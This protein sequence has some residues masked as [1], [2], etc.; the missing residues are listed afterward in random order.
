MKEEDK[1]NKK[2]GKENPFT[3]PEGYFDNL[4][5]EIMSKLP[6]KE[7][8]FT[9]EKEISMWQRVR[10]WLYMAA[11]FIAILLPIRFMINQTTNP[12]EDAIT[13]TSIENEVYEDD[14]ID[15]IVNQSMMDDY[16]LYLYLTN[17]DADNIYN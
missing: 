1:L 2:Y 8:I 17:A 12:D 10:P 4:T 3:V 13:A 9:E 16:S 5:H 11:M 14:Y 15:V 6:E 7:T